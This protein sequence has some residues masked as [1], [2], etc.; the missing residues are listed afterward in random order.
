MPKPGE[1]EVIVKEEKKDDDIVIVVQS[2]NTIKKEPVKE[3]DKDEIIKDL[4]S[5]LDKVEKQANYAAG[6]YRLVE[7][8]EK[9]IQELV[10]QKSE[11]K[12]EEPKTDEEL[13]ELFNKD[14]VA[15][16]AEVVKRTLAAEKEKEKK[17]REL[18]SITREQ[19][20]QIEIFETNKQQVLE[21]Y[22]E[23]TDPTSEYTKIWLEIL[24]NHPEYKSNY[25]G[26][27]L[28]MREMENEAR[29]R[30]LQVKEE[31]V[32][33][34][35]IID[36][37]VNR[38][39]RVRQTNLKPGAKEKSGG[40]EVILTQDQIT[41]CKHNNIPLKVYAATLKRLNSGEKKVEVDN[42]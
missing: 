18:E 26:P 20:R 10:R 41:L 21:K 42:G 3:P 35:K 16:T 19:T 32:D 14:I 22:N 23:L 2:D 37:E 9:Q 1:E 38:R 11:T 8:L 17:S 33:A 13:V 30:G 36:K 24:D 31:G 25:L 28:T 29:R 39:E 15:G 40:G 5:K 12:K 7:K 34:D 6:S 27:I 4:K